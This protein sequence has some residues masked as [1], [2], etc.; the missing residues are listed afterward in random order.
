MSSTARH[1][2]RVRLS[3]SIVVTTASVLSLASCSLPTGTSDPSNADASDEIS[4]GLLAPLTGPSAADGL[5]MKNGAELAVAQ[6]NEQGGVDGRTV[7]LKTADV[8]GQ[9]AD[10]VSAAVNELTADPSVVAV[11][12]GYASTTNFEIDL[13][14]EVGMPYI[15]GGNSDQTV[16]ITSADPSKYPT[17]WSLAPSYAGYTTDLPERLA[18]WDADG[19]YELRN[20]NVYI[21]SSDNPYS[22]GIASGLQ[23]TLSE[24]GWAVFGPDTVPFGEVSDWTTQLAKIR[25]TD[26]AIIINTDYLTANAAKFI[27]QF[28]QNPTDA[29]VFSQYAPSVPEFL[30]L[31]GN[32]ADGVLYNLPIAALPTTEAGKKVLDDY[33]QAYGSDPGLYGVLVHEEIG[34]WA[35]A[36]E[37]VGDPTNKAEVGAEIGQTDMTTAVGRVVFDQDTHLAKSGDDFIPFT[38]YQVQ[39]GK[40]VVI[41]PERYAEGT[42]MKPSWVQ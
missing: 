40:R 25:E 28:S 32:S 41:S 13:F 42:L 4:I 14:A 18:Q 17:V 26:P 39:D 29:L 36:A 3:L 31:A 27:T 20:Q 21:V 22:N 10:A 35:R 38:V 1:R 7:T 30:D 19:T 11:F 37:A 34:I 2:R 33:Q 24:D 12:A 6:L 5:L 8:K 9:S 23:E 16:A 15:I